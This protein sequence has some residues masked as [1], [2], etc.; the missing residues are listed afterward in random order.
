MK[1]ELCM[2][3][4]LWAAAYY[5]A[6]FTSAF[7]TGAVLPPIAVLFAALVALQGSVSATL[8]GTL[9]GTACMARCLRMAI[10]S[11]V[12]RYVIFLRRV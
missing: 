8:F 3:M 11:T 7:Q 6:L 9:A 5:L 10:R 2:E 1:F 12:D 4:S